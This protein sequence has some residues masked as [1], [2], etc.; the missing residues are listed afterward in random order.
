[1]VVLS[2]TAYQHFEKKNF[3]FKAFVGKESLTRN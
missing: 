2:E 1:M 3:F